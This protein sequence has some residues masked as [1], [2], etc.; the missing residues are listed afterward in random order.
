[1]YQST[2]SSPNQRPMTPPERQEGP[3]RYRLLAGRGAAADDQADADG[4]TGGEPDQDRRRD[5]GAEEEAHH[6]DQLHVPH[7]HPARIG[8]RDDEQHAAGGGGGDRA[9]GEAVGIA[10]RGDRDR[11]DRPGEHDL[12]R[13]H[14]QVEVGEGDD[15]EHRAEHEAERQLAG[16]LGPEDQHG[17]GEQHR[18]AELGQRIAPGDPLAAAAAASARARARRRPARCRRPRSGRRRWG[19]ASARW[20]SPRRAATGRRAP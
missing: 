18:G 14:P 8:K 10:E 15:D 7:P 19:S 12:V 9:L 16:V 6:R 1:M 3:E 5:R 17:R 13:D 20:P 11:G 4:G 2:I